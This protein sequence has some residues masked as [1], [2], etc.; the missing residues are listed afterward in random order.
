MTLINILPLVYVIGIFII[1]ILLAKR[2]FFDSLRKNH[3][4]F[5][6]MAFIFPIIDIFQTHWALLYGKE[7]NP[8]LLFILSISE[9]FGWISFVILHVAFSIASLILF[10]K[11]RSKNG[12]FSR[13]CVFLFGFI[14]A[15]PVFW[16][17]IAMATWGFF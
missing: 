12:S 3:Y 8:I 10:W 11:G 1:A 4:L 17:I 14:W 6:F 9:A 5:A 2:G 7:G 16:N 13:F 15:F